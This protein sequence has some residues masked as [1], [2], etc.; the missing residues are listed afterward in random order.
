M[1]YT[2]FDAHCDTLSLAADSGAEVRKNNFHT[3]LERMGKYKGYTQVFACFIEPCFRDGAFERFL[4]M[5]DIFAG[6]CDGHILSLEG[7]EAITSLAALRTMARLGVRIA[8]LTWNYSNHIAGGVLEPGGGLTEFGCGVVKEMNRINMLVDYSHLNDRSFFEIAA[9]SAM[10]VVATHSNS[11]AV[12]AHPRNLTDEQFKLIIKTGG[13]AGINFYPWFLND[14]GKA[15]IDDIVKHIEHFMSLGGGKN[16]GIG[17]DF[18][19]VD[20]LPEGICGCED[21]YKLFDRLLSLNYTD[22][23]TEDIA[24]RNFERIFCSRT[25]NKTAGRE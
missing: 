6:E 22:E 10:P 24:H 8:A 5:S 16:I 4:K 9:V 1:D 21:T 11:R 12:C 2:I 17:A 15:G 18:D 23:Q 7:G 25:Y 13:C 20:A 3:D 14:R 19:G